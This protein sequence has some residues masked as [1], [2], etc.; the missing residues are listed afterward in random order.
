METPILCPYCAD[1][2]IEEMPGVELIAK[3]VPGE[4]R[5]STARVFRCRLWHIFA[6][7]PQ[8]TF[9]ERQTNHDSAAA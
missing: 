2:E 5:I 6:V 1:R 8:P 3:N 7:F 9:K 4:R